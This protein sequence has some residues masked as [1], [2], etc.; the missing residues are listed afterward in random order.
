MEETTGAHTHREKTVY[1][2]SKKTAIC[3]PEE[4]ASGGTKSANNL[5]LDFKLIELWEN[6]FLLFKS[7]SLWYFITGSAANKYNCQNT[8]SS[9]QF[10]FC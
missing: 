5:I 7:S 10:S 9:M 1:E 2:H 3:K 6:K 4:E 8:I